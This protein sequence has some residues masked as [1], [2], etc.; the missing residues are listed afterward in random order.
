[1]THGRLLVR[2]WVG[3][4]A[5]ISQWGMSW[6]WSSEPAPSR[7]T[8]VQTETKNC[9]FSLNNE[10]KLHKKASIINL[11]SQEKNTIS[12]NL[13]QF[14]TFLFFILSMESWHNNKPPVTSQHVNRECVRTS[15]V[16]GLVLL[17]LLTLVYVPLLQ[18]LFGFLSPLGLGCLGCWVLSGRN[19]RMSSERP[20]ESKGKEC[21]ILDPSVTW[22]DMLLFLLTNGKR[23]LWL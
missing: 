20:Q 19:S 17:H 5:T 9:Q 8:K 3:Q 22:T 21:A 16:V 11:F 13:I 23:G 6:G 4:A 7:Q 18:F 10:E 14:Y 2:R 12:Q 1:M 15:P